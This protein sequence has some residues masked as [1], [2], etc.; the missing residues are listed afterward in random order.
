MREITNAIIEACEEGRLSWETVARECL[1][2]MSEQQVSE[3]NDVA[4]FVGVEDETEDSEDED[5][6]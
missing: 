4:E 1:E 5:T 2:Y 3:M 6:E